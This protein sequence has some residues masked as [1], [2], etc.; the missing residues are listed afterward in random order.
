MK[1]QPFLPYGTQAIDDEEIN[2][3]LSVLTSDFL[4][5][6]PKIKEFEERMREWTGARYCAAVSSGTAALHLAVKALDLEKGKKG[7]TSPLTFV[8]T[9]NSLLYNG[10]K[11]GFV[12]IDENTYC[13][14]PAEL[15]QR[16]D[17]DTAVILP[18]HFAGQPAKM[19]EIS[20]IAWERDIFI[21]EDAAH[22]V[23]SRY[24]NGQLVGSCCYS[25]V[26]AFSFHPVKTITTGEGGVITTNHRG[27]YEKILT[28]RNHGLT[29]DPARFKIT[30]STPPGPW[31]YEMQEL[32][33][34]Y[35]MTD[36]QAAIGIGQL[37]K[38]AGFIRRREEIVNLY[39][40][41]LKALEW[42]TIPYQRPGVAPVLHLYVVLIDFERIGK[43]R[44][45]I[46]AELKARGIGT[47]V[48]YI[49]VHLH[50]YYREHWGFQAGDFPRAERYYRQCLSIPLF[51]KM[52]DEDVQ[53][54]INVLKEVGNPSQ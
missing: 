37:N 52:T 40:E 21:I 12:D 22:A 11:P 27:I 50:P 33:F 36:I 28:L 20:E 6:G 35:R 8:A 19:P 51:P 13:L 3:V 44:D 7:L 53:R 26:T 30:H 48:H 5:S 31:Y 42:L 9:A 23:G 4:S 41:K 15:K 32:G 43:T 34:N 10:L 1:E 47:Q 25:D 29:K 2:Q 46:M 38:L 14:H 49:P 24:E 18:V 16:I 39:N 17:D 45:Q 54:V